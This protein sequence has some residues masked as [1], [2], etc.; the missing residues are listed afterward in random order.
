MKNYMK[1]MLPSSFLIFVW[2]SIRFLKG[3]YSR[4][5]SFFAAMISYLL[6]LFSKRL[7]V[8]I[9]DRL[10]IIVKL[11]HHSY[12][13]YL[14]ADSPAEYLTRR[15]SCKKEPETIKWI[16]TYVHPND[17]VYDIGANVGV[18]SFVADKHTNGNAKI[19]AFEPGFSTFAQ[20]SRNISLNFCQGRIIPFCIAL[21]D[22]NSLA[23]FN[24]SSIAPGT[25]LHALGE[26]VDNL[27]KIFK[28]AYQQPVISYKL[29]DFIKFFKLESPT[30]IKLDVDGIEL[31]ILRGSEETLKSPELKS[32]LVE[33]E[34]SQ[35]SS[36]KIVKYLEER[37]FYIAMTRS[38]GYQEVYTSNYLFLRKSV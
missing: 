11:D 5:I 21:S 38:H 13:I 32:V 23:L 25:A 30:H 33:V 8:E 14:Y 28:P 1:N 10:S 12:D 18:Y 19:Y 34:P 26:P 4:L 16:E 17:V 36:D 29:D 6:I 15:N 20:L 22:A 3:I 2:K 37:G 7:A 35:E 31:D 24:Y 27:G 9:K